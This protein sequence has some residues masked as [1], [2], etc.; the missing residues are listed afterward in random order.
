MAE[1]IKKGVSGSTIIRKLRYP[2]IP[3]GSHVGVARAKHGGESG[4]LFFAPAPLAR[5]LE[6]PMVAHHFQCPFA[7][8]LFLEPP[9]GFLHGFAFFKLYLGQ[10]FLTSSPKTWGHGRRSSPAFLSSHWAIRY[11]ASGGCQTRYKEWRLQSRAT[12]FCGGSEAR[13]FA[14]QNRREAS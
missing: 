2:I 10:T 3:F 6:M 13:R 7:V 8:D 4:R 1:G 9:Q 11:V 5:L 14:S 12:V